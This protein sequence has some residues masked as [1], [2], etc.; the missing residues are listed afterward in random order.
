MGR[1]S[2]GRETSQEN[3]PFLNAFLRKNVI[4]GL[5]TAFFVGFIV[6]MS[7]LAQK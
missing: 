2:P 6:L 7:F 5:Q 1:R 3:I 4:F